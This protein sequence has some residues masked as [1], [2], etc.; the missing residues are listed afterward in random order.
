[1]SNTRR[2]QWSRAQIDAANAERLLGEL[3]D[4]VAAAPWLAPRI[5][6]LWDVLDGQGRAEELPAL[7]E[8]FH[9]GWAAR[10]RKMVVRDMTARLAAAGVSPGLVA[11]AE[12]AAMDLGDDWWAARY[13]ELIEKSS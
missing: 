12:R 5:A 3:A 11:E 13:H 4:A 8:E 10:F 7:M 1:M 9:A 2:P 6:E